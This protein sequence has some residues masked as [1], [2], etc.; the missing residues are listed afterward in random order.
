MHDAAELGLPPYL[1][2]EVAASGKSATYHTTLDAA[3][4]ASDI[5]Y[6]TRVQKERF[7]SPEEYER[8]KHVYVITPE[9]MA[10][11]KPRMA[12][13]HPLPRVGEIAPAVDADPRAAYFRQM[14]YGLYVRMALLALVMGVEAEEV[15][16][17]AGN[18]IYE[19]GK[20]AAEAEKAAAWEAKQ[21]AKAAAAAAGDSSDAA[22]DGP[23]DAAADAAAHAAGAATG[24]ASAASTADSGS[25]TAAASAGAAAP[26]AAARSAPVFSS[27]SK[28][29]KEYAQSKAAFVRY[30]E[31]TY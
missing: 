26:A 2:A 18:A 30:S 8:L 22:A 24:G 28:A 13:M 5:L 15:A 11:A 25:G 3:V 10:R 16:F 7:S 12:V 27:A 9:V 31:F 4:A 23:A 19:H 20:R 6:V 29:A 21:K 1:V 14:R 17:T